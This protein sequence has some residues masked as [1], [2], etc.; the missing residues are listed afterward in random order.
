MAAESSI[1]SRILAAGCL[2][3]AL[4][5]A[6]T[7]AVPMIFP[8][9][10]ESK[11]MITAYSRI[12][13]LSNLGLLVTLVVQIFVVHVS[14]KA[15][16]RAILLASS[17]GIAGSLL[18]L[19][20][21]SSFIV[22][23]LL[24]LLLRTVTSVYHPLVIAWISKTQLSTGLDLA[25]G[26]QS[27]S[28]NAG[29][30][31]AFISVGFLCQSYGW[32][33]PLLVWAAMAVV[34]GLTAHFIL[35][36]ITSRERS[37]PAL[38]LGS[39]LA[40]LRRVKHFIPGFFFGGMGWS[41]TIF[42]APSLLNHEFGV[43]MGRTGL[44]L[45]MWIGL[46]TVSGYGYGFISRRLGRRTVFLMSMGG[47]AVSLAVIGLAPGRTAAVIGLLGFGMLLLMTYPSLHTFVGS[48]VGPAEQ[49]QAFSW[50]SNIQIFSGALITLLAGFLSDALGIR[51][52]FLL[53][54]GLAALCF[55]YYVLTPEAGAGRPAA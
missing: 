39:W 29:V 44:F 53:S 5:D 49:T 18:F 31:L 42:Y 14:Q 8:V 28:G 10:Y 52:P 13:I 27:G 33:T 4:N 34:L 12:G 51:T 2:L 41:V 35:A 38:D 20:R 47:A 26:T 50:V 7:T 45:A 36:G 11:F 22:L 9:L 24:F 17:L 16:Y 30:L 15:E 46:G 3:H 43:P 1:K 48:T 55:L 21:A 37:L 32:R 6:A 25:M 40:V 23:L 54:S 19:T